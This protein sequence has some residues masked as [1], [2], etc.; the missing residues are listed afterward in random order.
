MT[1]SD[2]H[3]K[4]TKTRISPLK[5]NNFNVKVKLFIVNPS[6]GLK[7][8]KPQGR[9]RIIQSNSLTLSLEPSTRYQC[10]TG[11]DGRK[12][13]T[14]CGRKPK[15]KTRSRSINKINVLER[16]TRKNNLILHG[17]KEDGKSYLELVNLVLG[18]LNKTI[19][20]SQNNWDKWKICY[21]T[22]IGK[23]GQEKRRPVLIT[24][25]RDWRRMELFR[26]KKALPKNMY[27]T[28]DYPKEV[29]N[30]RKK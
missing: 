30:K 19:E 24:V 5:Q 28:E 21:A 14:S 26:N 20:D 10:S 2:I 4:T 6:E 8:Y 29:L 12:T 22:R 13:E 7:G 1:A 27:I 16:S 25:T 11:H 15:I 17:L 9:C 18:S 23:R 3:T